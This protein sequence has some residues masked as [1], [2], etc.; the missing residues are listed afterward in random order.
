[1]DRKERNKEKAG[2][3][4]YR[5]MYRQPANGRKKGEKLAE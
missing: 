1:M 3:K 4:I 2:S 5:K